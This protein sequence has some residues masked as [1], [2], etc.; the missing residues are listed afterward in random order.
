[1]AKLTNNERSP[2]TDV[3]KLTWEDLK[4]IG[5]GGTKQIATIPAGG[6]VSL[7]A[8]TNTVDIG[9]T[10]TLVVDVGTTL[11]DPDEFINALD[12]DGMTVGLPTYNTGDTMLQSAGT[13]T[14]LAGFV[15]A[16]LVSTDTPVYIKVTDANIATITAGE[17][18]I[19]LTILDLTQFS[20]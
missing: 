16:K 19:G 7:C 3:V 18:L 6:G 9:T 11:A 14:T 8:V 4:A 5:N 17:L 10:T 12:V 15:P 20:V 13:T 2:F 1:M